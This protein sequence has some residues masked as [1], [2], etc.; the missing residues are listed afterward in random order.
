MGASGAVRLVWER[1]NGSAPRIVATYDYTDEDGALLFQCVRKFP[2]KFVQRRPRRNDTC[3]C[4][5]FRKRKDPDWIWNLHKTRRVLY[6]QRQVIEAVA[7]GR[8]IWVVEGEEPASLA[9]A[10]H[11]AGAAPKIC[12]RSAVTRVRVPE[13]VESHDSG[14]APTTTDGTDDAASRARGARSGPDRAR[15]TTCSGFHAGL[16]Q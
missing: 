8:R 16:V 3:G 4:E 9:S 2:K 5:E 14:V 13:F 11:E 1:R 6:R 10:Q 12:E 15:I 7:T